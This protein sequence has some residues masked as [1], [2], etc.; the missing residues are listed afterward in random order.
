MSLLSRMHRASVHTLG[1]D[2]RHTGHNRGGK[3]AATKQGEARQLTVYHEQT[4]AQHPGRAAI[5]APVA[6][7]QLSSENAALLADVPQPESW[8]RQ[9]AIEAQAAQAVPE[10][11]N[12][13][14][15]IPAAAI[16]AAEADALKPE[17]AGRHR[18]AETLQESD[19]QRASRE[20]LALALP[21]D[22]HRDPESH[23]AQAAASPF[24]FGGQDV[25]PASHSAEGI[26]GNSLWQPPLEQRIPGEH[27]DAAQDVSQMP[28]HAVVEQGITIHD[29]SVGPARAPEAPAHQEPTQPAEADAAD[30]FGGSNTRR[31]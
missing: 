15:E 25:E 5:E 31:S 13:R 16:T 23:A 14:P 12:I 21:A 3:H 24:E 30:W 4:L 19:A 18:R 6:Q 26:H 8:R 28:H 29:N 2:G 20:A 7:P 1:M 10:A 17:Y 11:S 22:A 27:Y 9:P